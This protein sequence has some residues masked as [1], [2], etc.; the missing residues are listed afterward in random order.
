VED[1]DSDLF[2]RRVNALKLALIIFGAVLLISVFG[3]G[4]SHRSGAATYEA[5]Q[6]SPSYSRQA[7]SET[8]RADAFTSS[9]GAYM[10]AREK[11][12]YESDPSSLGYTDSDRQ[13]LKD[14]GVS[15]SEARAAET[16]LHQQ[17]ID[18]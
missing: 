5:E 3:G 9:T 13:F 12:L 6:S 17:G 2:R 4:A 15:E 18:D 10:D 14:H 1:P 11:Q 16:V 8:P 7:S